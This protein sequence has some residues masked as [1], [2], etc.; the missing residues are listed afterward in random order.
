MAI[1]GGQQVVGQSLSRVRQVRG[2]LW[3]VAA[4]VVLVVAGVGCAA[5]LAGVVPTSSSLTSSR[6]QDVGFVLSAVALVVLMVAAVRVARAGWAST[7]AWFLAPASTRGQRARALESVRAGQAVDEP[8]MALTVAVAGAA[9]RQ[10]R[11]ALMWVA[12]A[13]I[14]ADGA[15]GMATWWLALVTAAVAAMGVL[16]AITA[17]DARR[18]RRWLDAHQSA[19]ATR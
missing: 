9:A 6:L 11:G 14:F 19:G 5:A 10:G 7:S 18:A 17:R 8:A 15:L 16:A 2:G 13:L 1:S 3:S 4:A 12:I